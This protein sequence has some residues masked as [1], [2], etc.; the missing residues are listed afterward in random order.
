MNNKT[1]RI[2][3]FALASVLVSGVPAVSHAEKEPVSEEEYVSYVVKNG[4]TL[5]HI[6]LK[7]YG[8]AAYWEKLAEYNHLENPNE[9]YVGQVINVPKSMSYDYGNNIVTVETYPEDK[10][11]TVKSGDTMYCIV[12]AQYGLKNQE[13]VDKLATYNNMSDPNKLCVG[14]VLLIPCVEKLQNV[15]QNDYTEEYNRMGWKLN[16]PYG[17]KPFH[18][19]PCDPCHPGQPAIIIF[20]DCPT[21]HH[22]KCKVKTHKPCN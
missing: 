19:N 10:T 9:L 1:K 6:A 11:Y 4:D 8:N 21:Q 22:D 18:K 16:H 20:P 7:Y 2:S 3:S 15:V 14:Q 5:G 13:S 17:C 12:N